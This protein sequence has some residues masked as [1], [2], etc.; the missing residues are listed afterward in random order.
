MWNLFVQDAF[1]QQVRAGIPEIHIDEEC[2]PW[3]LVALLVLI[4]L[5]PRKREGQTKPKS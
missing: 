5:G 4:A 1:A 3:V 2:I